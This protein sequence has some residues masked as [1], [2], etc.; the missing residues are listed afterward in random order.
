M[1]QGKPNSDEGGEIGKQI[2]LLIRAKGMEANSKSIWHIVKHWKAVVFEIIT[3][4]CN[5]IRYSNGKEKK[6]S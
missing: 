5:L 2:T 3:K 4:L 1:S 6:Y